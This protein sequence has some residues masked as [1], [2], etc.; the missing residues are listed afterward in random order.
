MFAEDP[1]S[2]VRVKLAGEV[3]AN[4]VTGQ[5][6]STFKETPQLPFE[7]FTVHF[8]GGERAPLA[9]PAVCGAYTTTASFEPWSGNQAAGA[10]ST[11]DIVSGPNASACQSP[12]GFSPSLSGGSTNV[13]AGAFTSFTSTIGREDGQQ[14]LKAL[15]LH[16]PNGLEGDPHERHALRRR[17]SERGELRP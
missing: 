8:F 10:S 17:T 13:Q 12:P 14:N 6:V 15:S 9:T 3:V 11:F 7:D 5:L 4:P 2:G 16:M 1:V